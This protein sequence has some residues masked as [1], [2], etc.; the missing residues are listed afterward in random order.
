MDSSE[1]PPE[2]GD[3]VQE[4]ESNE[5]STELTSGACQICE[6]MSPLR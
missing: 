1:L 5:I 4:P 6:P 3:S 2:H